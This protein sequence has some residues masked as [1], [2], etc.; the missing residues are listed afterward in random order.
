MTTFI[1]STEPMKVKISQVAMSN[2]FLL[3]QDK[4]QI[5]AAIQLEAKEAQRMP[6]L[7]EEEEEAEDVDD[8]DD[9]NYVDYVEID[10]KN[11]FAPVSLNSTCSGATS[12]PSLDSVNS[13]SSTTSTS[14]SYSSNQPRGILRKPRASAKQNQLPRG[15]EYPVANFSEPVGNYF[16]WAAMWQQPFGQSVGDWDYSS[17]TMAQQSWGAAADNSRVRRG[18]RRSRAG[19]RTVS[20]NVIGFPKSKA[21][22]AQVA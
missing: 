22:E 6:A 7:I 19:G 18:S 3:E 9:V 12:T 21:G 17:C 4:A 13:G 8:V 16:G 14:S 10:K 15:L 11:F 1:N 2:N 5:A 20:L